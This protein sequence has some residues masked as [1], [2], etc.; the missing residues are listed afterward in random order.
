M[1]T[2]LAIFALSCIALLAATGGMPARAGTS[3][4]AAPP[5]HDLL[6]ELKPLP[7]DLA[8]HRHLAELIPRLP[9]A[10]QSTGRQLLAALDDQLGLYNRALL[11]FPFDNRIVPPP[12]IPLPAADAWQA[13]GAVAAIA[14]L[15][16]RHR[17][18]MVNEAHHDAHTRVLTLELLPKLYALG[19][20]Y[21]AVEALGQHDPDLAKRGHATSASGSEYLHE[22]VYGEI[23]RQAIHLGYTLVPYDSDAPTL[24]GREAAQAGN[25]YRRVFAKD[26][27]ARLLVHAG[28]AHVDKAPGNLGGD[29]Q[30]MAM[31]LAQLTGIEPLSIDQTQFRDI[32]PGRSDP[33]AYGVLVERFHPARPVVLRNGQT[34]QLW[35]A[36][37]ARHD[38]SVILPPVGNAPRPHW[39]TLGGKR[40]PRLVNTTLCRD[41]LPC[42][43]EAHYADEPDNATAADR[44]TFLHD[45]E[46]NTLY[47]YPGRYRLRG[48]DAGGHTLGRRTLDVGNR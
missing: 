24:G 25:L 29:A 5:A 11:E 44:Y 17:I 4:T 38:V 35:S 26:P 12:K 8:R 47:L 41:R 1:P 19:F 13:E 40:R 39:L 43:V 23:V 20:R 21:L 48:V 2:R 42:I 9:E 6:G 46:Q 31:R 16:R 30:P 28:Y 33:G 32:D 3:T 36:D 14:T 27:Q 18:V 37:P 45:D 22:P 15:A 10:E 7:N 34:G